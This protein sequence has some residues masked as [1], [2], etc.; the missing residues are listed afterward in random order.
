MRLLR[1]I[2]V[3]VAAAFML[4]AG[5]SFA[6][7]QN[8]SSLKYYDAL[9]FRMINKGFDNTLTPFTRI[10]ASSKTACATT[11][12]SAPSAQAA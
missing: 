12:G 7:A 8:A 9:K 2:K 3:A 1:K 5:F 6:S 10:P 11:C 4:A